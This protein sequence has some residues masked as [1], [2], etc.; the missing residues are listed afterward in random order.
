M[1][2]FIALFLS[3][4]L[5]FAFSATNMNRI[6]SGTVTLWMYKSTD[7]IATITGSGYFND[8][9]NQLRE[10][11]CIIAV[12]S[13]GGTQTVDLLVVTSA[14]NATPVTVTNGT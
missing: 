14:D 9:V 5:P 10:N 13:S 12:G 1:K 3:R 8:H 2:T 11:D 4:F 6:H 7:T